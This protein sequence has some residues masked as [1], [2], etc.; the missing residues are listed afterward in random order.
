LTETAQRSYPKLVGLRYLEDAFKSV[1]H[2]RV[3]LDAAGEL[4]ARAQ[5]QR[6]LAPIGAT[7]QDVDYARERAANRSRMHVDVR[8][9]RLE[10]EEAMVKILEEL[11]SVQRVRV[12]PPTALSNVSSPTVQETRLHRQPGEASGRGGYGG[13]GSNH[14]LIH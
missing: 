14:D 6:V 3:R 4:L 1:R 13:C 12:R 7:V 11:P 5:L 8:L 2:L 9:P 10:V